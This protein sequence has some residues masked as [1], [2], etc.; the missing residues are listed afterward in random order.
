[1]MWVISKLN[2][3]LKKAQGVPP[4]IHEKGKENRKHK[5]LT[6]AIRKKT[7]ETW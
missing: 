5:K 3:I 4:M 6:V 7:E 1:M 2:E